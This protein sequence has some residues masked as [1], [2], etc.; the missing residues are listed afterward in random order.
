MAITHGIANF[1]ASAE[2]IRRFKHRHDIRGRVLQGEASS[3]DVVN[4]HIAQA[5]LPKLLRRVSGHETFNMDETGLNYRAQPNRTLA[6]QPRAGI[7]LA[8]DRVTAVL[9]VNAT[10]THNCRS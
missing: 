7:K 1:K 6:S 4:I 10:R 5:M 8:K 3:A 9:C 2:W